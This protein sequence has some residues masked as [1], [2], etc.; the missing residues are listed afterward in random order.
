VAQLGVECDAGTVVVVSVDSFERGA[1]A[2]AAAATVLVRDGVAAA[3]GVTSEL[4]LAATATLF[5]SKLRLFPSAH[6]AAAELGLDARV[7]AGAVVEG[8]RVQLLSVADGLVEGTLNWTVSR[9]YAWARAD[10]GGGAVMEASNVPVRHWLLLLLPLHSSPPRPPSL[11]GWCGKSHDSDRVQGRS[12]TARDVLD[13]QEYPTRNYGTH[14]HYG[15]LFSL[16]L[17]YR[18]SRSQALANRS[19]VLLGSNQTHAAVGNLTYSGAMH[20]LALSFPPAPPAF[21]GLWVQQFAVTSTLDP[22]PIMLRVSMRVVAGAVSRLSAVAFAETHAA[23][24]DAATGAAV[25]T[26]G[27]AVQL[28]VRPRDRF[29]NSI[30][31]GDGVYE[32]FMRRAAGPASGTWVVTEPAFSPLASTA[33][34]AVYDGSVLGVAPAGGFTVTVSALVDGA[35]LPLVELP[36]RAVAK[37]CDASQQVRPPPPPSLSLLRDVRKGVTALRPPAGGPSAGVSSGAERWPIRG[38]GALPAA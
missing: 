8:M 31:G 27:G 7:T 4:A 3:V 28:T 18:A 35:V 15:L 5:V 1:N 23:A 19:L 33:W 13:E 9:T 32:I 11:V 12:R 30:G 25:V 34:A 6:V 10:G 14:M 2:S 36:V 38:G 17:P 21:V 26:A 29:N 22:A 24:L 16:S 20:D 37:V